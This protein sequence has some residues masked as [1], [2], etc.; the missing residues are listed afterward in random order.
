MPSGCPSIL[1]C[2]AINVGWAPPQG[3]RGGI[4]LRRL[5]R[6]FVDDANSD[7]APSYLIA[8]ANLGYVARFGAWQLTG[9]ARGD[10][11]FDCKY[12]GSVIVNEGNQRFFEPAPGRT[13]L[14]GFN[15]LYAF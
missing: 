5:S 6:V 11:L 7:A 4:D 13:W 3:W 15:A 12:A 1:L 14:V 2:A 9:F 10:N 8:G